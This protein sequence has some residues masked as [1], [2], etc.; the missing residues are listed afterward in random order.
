VRDRRWAAPLVVFAVA[1]A[2]RL[3]VVGLA[4][5]IYPDF[6]PDLYDVLARNLL[7]GHGL[8]YHAESALPTVTR[9]PV[10]AGVIAAAFALGGDHLWVAR[11]ACALVDAATAVLVWAL[12]VATVRTVARAGAEGEPGEA[13]WWPPPPRLALLA[14][15]IYAL[16]PLTVYWTVKVVPETLLAFCL[17]LA[18]LAFEWWRRGPSWGRAATIGLL[19]GVTVLVKSVVLGLPVVVAV[20]MAAT[21]YVRRR[22]AAAGAQER[23]G[24]SG[25][26]WRLGV[27]PAVVMLVV[28][29]V[30]APWTW[31]N[32]HVSGSF[33]PVQTLTW[34]NFWVDIDTG[35]GVLNP[36]FV[37]RLLSWGV[38]PYP[39]DENAR[40]DVAGERVLRHEARE[41]T[42][43]HPRAALQKTVINLG[44]LWYRGSESKVRERASMAISLLQMP[45]VAIGAWWALWGAGRRRGVGYLAALCLAV[46]LYLDLVYAPIFALFRYS[47]PAWPFLSIL[48]ALG[49][50]VVA[51]RLRRREAGTSP[52]ATGDGDD[53]E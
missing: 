52:A 4:P 44:E 51:A 18:A 7:H 22:R 41:W 25:G 34:Y 21:L 1:A 53:G 29:L 14:G 43:E 8:T 50:M 10:F 49:L 48:V 40:A 19:L 16:Q 46:P 38:S 15:L 47:L 32:Y 12:V 33:V 9:G 5:R 20:A 23:G 42:R 26:A 35:T 36:T 11:A 2:V 17:V 37:D 39:Y 30:V 3:I 27:Q 24:A 13:A 6:V 28:C 45:L 31:R